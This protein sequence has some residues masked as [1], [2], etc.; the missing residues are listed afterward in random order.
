LGCKDLNLIPSTERKKKIRQSPINK[1]RKSLDTCPVRNTTK[2]PS[3]K[4]ADITPNSSV[5]TLNINRQA[6]HQQLT[7]I[8]LAT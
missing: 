5:N 3:G 6:G 4:M 7:P 8:I 2:I 1:N